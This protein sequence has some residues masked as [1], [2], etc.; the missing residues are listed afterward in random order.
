MQSPKY[1]TLH[2]ALYICRV[3]RLGFNTASA[4]PVN[5]DVSERGDSFCVNFCVNFL[6]SARVRIPFWVF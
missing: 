3:I 1:Y 4:M 5:T 6:K 2:F